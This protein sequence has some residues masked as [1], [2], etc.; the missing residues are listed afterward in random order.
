MSL[1]Y[2]WYPEQYF[3][4]RR[5][6]ESAGF[7]PIILDELIELYV[8]RERTYFEYYNSKR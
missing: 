4:V 6:I 5:I 8:N 2:I 7:N 1:S 3:M